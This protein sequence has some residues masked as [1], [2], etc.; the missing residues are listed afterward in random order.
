M[1][2]PALGPGAG[3]PQLHRIW[4]STGLEWAMDLADAG[5]LVSLGLKPSFAC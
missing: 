1:V 4:K 2:N 3:A 5:K